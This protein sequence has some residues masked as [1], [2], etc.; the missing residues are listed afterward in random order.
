MRN[1]VPLVATRLEFLAPELSAFE[2]VFQRSGEMLYPIRNRAG[3]N[4]VEEGLEAG[5]QRQLHS[6]L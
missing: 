4:P 2:S 5:P 6:V 3:R 1:R